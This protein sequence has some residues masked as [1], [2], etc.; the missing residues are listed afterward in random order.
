MIVQHAWR[1]Q[2]MML[3]GSRYEVEKAKEFFELHIG[4]C[5][6]PIFLLNRRLAPVDLSPAVLLPNG[7]PFS[8]GRLTWSQVTLQSA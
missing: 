7:H 5:G 3:A 2:Q 8:L 6:L 1:H 4:T